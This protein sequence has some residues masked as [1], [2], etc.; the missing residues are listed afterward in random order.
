MT[1][2]A[3]AHG[4]RRV[5]VWAL[6]LAL[7]VLVS[8][9]GRKDAEPAPER[10]V[11]TQVLKVAQAGQILEF[12]AEV[13]ARTESRLAFR[14]P[15]K[16]LSRSVG[17]GDSV[18]AG[19]VLMR[20]DPADLKLAA[21][22]AE[23]ALTAA[24]ANRDQQVADIKRF[25]EL[26]NQGFISGAE[27]E[28]RE[29]ALQAAQAQYEQARAQAKA[30]RNQSQYAALEADAAGVI[31]S[32]DAEPGTVVAAGT[33]VLRLAQ[34]GPRDVVFQVPEHQVLALRQ[35]AAQPGALAVRLWGQSELLPAKLRELAEAADPVTRTFTAKV[36]IGAE[37]PVKLGQTATVLLSSPKQTGVVKLPMAAVFEAKGQTQVWV[38]DP[39]T[40]TVRT[41]AIQVAGA[42][43]NEVVVSS[44]L[45]PTQEVV[46]AGVHALSP[47][48]KV[49]RYGA[50]AGKP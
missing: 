20:L 6:G 40:M 26:K 18:K 12:A 49:R 41:Q 19:Q 47:G 2:A 45:S 16:V 22:A 44:G 39:A 38:L 24:K 17:L 35:L 50:P 23:A 43:G 36:D 37:A 28:R 25:R 13:R 34:K 15:G 48:Q 14:V 11:R 3:G 8:G 27:L 10:A 1:A 7:G 46:V 30:Q 31:T 9:C 42:D 5:G 29:A 33:P 32:V 21:D 4:R